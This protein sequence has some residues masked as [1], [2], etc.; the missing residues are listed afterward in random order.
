VSPFR[1]RGPDRRKGRPPAAAASAGA[2]GQPHARILLVEDDDD[3]RQLLAIALGGEGYQVAEAASAHEGL[4]RL[5]SEAFS[6][7]LSDYDLP[8]KTGAAM[9]K[10]AADAGV[11]RQTPT[12]LV[13]A[14]PEPEA[15]E[16]V[17]VIRKPLDLDRFL[18][19]VRNIL[20]AH[21]SAAPAAPSP[22]PAVQPAARLE[23][24]LYTSAKS[25]ASAKARA[26]LEAVLKECDGAT[27]SLEVCDLAT[28]PGRA[29]DDH[30]VFT[31]TLVKRQPPPRVWILG[32]LSNREVLVDL[33]HMCGA[34]PARR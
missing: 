25:G 24:V 21:G 13:T 27:V 14:H 28:N 10:E 23:L 9:L 30:V 7:V 20:R 6:L 32:D 34:P 31:P 2:R 26:N 33:L 8:G 17:E 16:N 11:L 5:R 15:I 18:Q 1:L 4:E 22:P 19:Q 12:L 29:E 3:T